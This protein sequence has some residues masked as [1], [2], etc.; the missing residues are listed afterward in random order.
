MHLAPE[1]AISADKARAFVETAW[2][3]NIHRGTDAAGFFMAHGDKLI[4]WKEKGSAKSK[5]MAKID[6]IPDLISVIGAHTRAS[7][8]GTGFDA[9]NNEN[10]HPVFVKDTLA[11]HNGF[12]ENHVSL[13]DATFPRVDSAAI[14][15]VFSDIELTKEAIRDTIRKLRGS[16]VFHLVWKNHPD[17]SLVVGGPV[18]PLSFYYDE[19]VGFIYSSESKGLVETMA[20]L[21][22]SG[23]MYEVFGKVWFLIRKGKIVLSGGMPAKTVFQK[24]AGKEVLTEVEYDPFPTRLELIYSKEN[25]S[26]ADTIFQKQAWKNLLLG[27]A[28][29]PVNGTK[30]PKQG[31]FNASPFASVLVSDMTYVGDM[32]GKLVYL[33]DMPGCQILTQSYGKVI[34]IIYPDMNVKWV[35][36]APEAEA[37]DLVEL[38]RKECSVVTKKALTPVVTPTIGGAGTSTRTGNGQRTKL[39][40]VTLPY[41]IRFKSEGTKCK[42]HAKGW[43][44]HP[45]LTKCDLFAAGVL[46]AL[47]LCLD[48][49]DVIL[50]Q[51]NRVDAFSRIKDPAC[52]HEWS[53]EAVFEIEYHKIMYSVPRQD[54][55]LK[56]QSI[57]EIDKIHILEDLW[58]DHNDLYLL[59]EDI[60]ENES[61]LMLG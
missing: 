28:T 19:N 40:T 29:L 59:V 2:L 51:S 11:I 53:L 38:I 55:C 10:N 45:Q 44:H 48:V 61:G 7:S 47:D 4:H 6:G 60:W 9:A 41:K 39:T 42:N 16:F 27:Q 56:C 35:E 46:E 43:Q 52:A 57:R 26:I 21:G 58:K 32:D 54:E 3:S 36:V 37:K 18:S 31:D 24:L 33:M 14:P 17:V 34:D 50:Q 25:G 20:S 12:I 49:E 13:K 5:N 30:I 1:F 23:K 22:I 8:S 15:L